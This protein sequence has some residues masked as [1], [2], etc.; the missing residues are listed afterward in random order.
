[1]KKITVLFILIAMLLSTFSVAAAAMDDAKLIIVHGLP[2]ADLA[3]D[4]TLPV[5][6][7]VNGVCSLQ[8]LVFGN[9]AAPM[10]LPA[11][12]Y[13]VAFSP[14]NAAAP[15]TNAALL[16]GDVTLAAYDVY[17]AV[18]HLSADN[19]AVLT[20]FKEDFSLTKPGKGRLVLHHTAAT[21]G[22]D[23]RISRSPK[24]KPLFAEYLGVVNGTS[25][26]T[27]IRPG[28]WRMA[29]YPAGMTTALYGP[30]K[31]RFNPK[32][33]Y[34]AYAIGNPTTGTFKVISKAFALPRFAKKK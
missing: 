23:V 3:L 31:L 28:T 33:V 10:A 1:M 17:S 19:L 2:G 30:A 20:F 5:D 34:L 32:K 29:I 7:S 24:F 16:E 9:I 21:A 26:T 22:V 15:C 18:A 14:A 12:A 13:H 4:P 25:V 6:V 11:G 27:E 8:N